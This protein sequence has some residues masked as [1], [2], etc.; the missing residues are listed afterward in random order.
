MRF[1]RQARTASAARAPAHDP[2]TAVPLRPDGL[3]TAV[4]GAGLLHLRMRPRLA[5]MRKRIADLLGYDYSRRLELDACGSLYYQLVDGRRSLREIADEMAR[6]GHGTPEEM[7]A[8]V[9]LFTKQLM[10]RNMI[11]LKV[12]AAPA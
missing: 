10:T 4:D 9:V 2:L 11:W 12:E 8:R 1:R 7:A 3:E 5:G 6:R